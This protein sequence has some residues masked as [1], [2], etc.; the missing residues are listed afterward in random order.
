[1]FLSN[2]NIINSLLMKKFNT[3]EIK[4]VDLQ[5]YILTKFQNRIKKIDFIIIKM[6]H[7]FNKEIIGSL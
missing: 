7:L 2:N 3:K 5:S 4:P 6:I 1:M